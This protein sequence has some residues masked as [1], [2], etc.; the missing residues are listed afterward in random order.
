MY[1][2]FVTDGLLHPQSTARTTATSPAGSSYALFALTRVLR[3]DRT[4]ASIT[5]DLGMNSDFRPENTA[6]E[7]VG[8]ERSSASEPGHDYAAA[9]LSAVSG[10]ISFR[11]A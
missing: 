9:R 5:A 6:C 8:Q 1:Q 11:P 7:Y 4:G 10:A 3:D 2:V